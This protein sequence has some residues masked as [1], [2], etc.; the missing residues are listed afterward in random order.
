M[1]FCVSGGPDVMC[2]DRTSHK[3]I[4]HKAV[5]EPINHEEESTTAAVNECFT[6]CVPS[7]LSA[8]Q[9]SLGLKG[10][11]RAV[12]F[13]CMCGK[14]VHCGYFQPKSISHSMDAVCFIHKLQDV[15]S[16]T[17]SSF[18]TTGGAKASGYAAG[19]RERQRR[20]RYKMLTMIYIKYLFKI[21]RRRK[22]KTCLL[23]FKV[24]DTQ[25]GL[26]RNLL[27]DG[28]RLC[29]NTGARTRYSSRSTFTWG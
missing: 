3:L 23:N 15:F 9:P 17:A 8:L 29:R 14:A 26:F 24:K 20:R 21:R 1:W 28:E 11:W 18:R 25:G 10:R 13:E 7:Q 5:N 12:C 16:V 27:I 6:G 2:P 4:R 19:C 22:G